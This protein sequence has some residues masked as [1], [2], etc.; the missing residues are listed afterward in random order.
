MS[1][2]KDLISEPPRSPRERVGL[3]AIAGRTIDK[4]RA[5][6]AGTL[7]DY[8]TNCPLDHMLLDWKGIGWE[9]FR[10]E[11]VAG[12]TDED[13]VRFLNENGVEKTPEEIVAWGK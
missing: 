6:L 10:A 2:A 13:V 12:G 5:S 7:G 4:C 3:Y 11:I 8:D 1:A 9:P